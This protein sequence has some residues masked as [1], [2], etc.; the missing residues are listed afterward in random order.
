MFYGDSNTQNFQK[1]RMYLVST[2]P[3]VWDTTVFS[4]CAGKAT[5]FYKATYITF[6]A[7]KSFILVKMEALD[8]ANYM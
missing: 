5:F 4:T 3:D 8:E 6:N 1:S 7:K 2:F